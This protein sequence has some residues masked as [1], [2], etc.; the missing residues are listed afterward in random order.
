MSFDKDIFLPMLGDGDG[1]GRVVA[2]L[3]E[4]G[5]AFQMG[6]VLLEVET[7]KAV[8]EVPA[9]EDGELVSIVAAAD[10]MVGQG[11]T[12]ARIKVEGEAPAIEPKEQIVETVPVQGETKTQTGPTAVVAATPNISQQVQSSQFCLDRVLATPVA[13]R[14]IRQHGLDPATLNGTGKNGR[15]QRDDVLNAVNMGVST[16]ANSNLSMRKGPATVDE[17][18]SHVKTADGDIA[19]KQWSTSA[20]TTP[21]TVILI[22]GLFADID[23][24]SAT[25]T[26]LA[27]NG[28]SVLALDLPNHGKSDSPVADFEDV[29]HVMGEAIANRVQLGRIVLCG[30]SYGGAVAA[31][32]SNM[33]GINCSGLCMI[34]PMGLGTEI[35]QGFLDGM[36]HSRSV[37][38]L[39]REMGKLTARA[40]FIPGTIYME[41][42]RQRLSESR[43]G[44]TDMCRSVAWDGIQ[45]I[46]IRP[47]LEGSNTPTKLIWGRR[48]EILPWQQ[49]LAAPASAALHLVPESGHM[50]QWEAGTLTQS[51]LS[52]MTDNV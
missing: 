17:K 14:L 35:N 31:R 3:V 36:T 20:P 22:H 41:G 28:A 4:E 48:D 37:Q 7:D 15:I 26:T 8:V 39:G 25:A 29:V 16:T 18:I 1:N 46:D 49:A 51:L 11:E 27:R 33:P 2:W 13:R 47:N 10:E 50:P 12:I 5:D 9:E 19:I 21:V 52:S 30:H 40:A 42:L 43:L 32:L 44:L 6:D 38:A 24:W 45:Q 23:A 34:S